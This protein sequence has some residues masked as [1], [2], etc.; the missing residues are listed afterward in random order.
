MRPVVI[1]RL[2]ISE[3]VPSYL[4]HINR[5]RII[6]NTVVCAADRRDRSVPIALDSHDHVLRILANGAEIA[7]EGVPQRR[8]YRYG[9]RVGCR[10]VA[11]LTSTPVRATRVRN[12]DMIIVWSAHIAR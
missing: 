9:S 7:S 6:P 8:P 11:T 1:A 12:G 2:K 10:R 3:D 5:I 4:S